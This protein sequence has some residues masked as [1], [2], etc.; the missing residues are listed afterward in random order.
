VVRPW[1]KGRKNG[2]NSFPF[3]DFAGYCKGFFTV[4]RP[5]VVGA[6]RSRSKKR[7][8]GRSFR[9]AA[10]GFP[11]FVASRRKSRRGM[12]IICFTTGNTAASSPK[13]IT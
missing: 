2:R 6:C 5:P 4:I 9:V 10:R 3:D 7:T 1:P 13:R 12:L 11:L 8:N